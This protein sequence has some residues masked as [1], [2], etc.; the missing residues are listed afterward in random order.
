[1]LPVLAGALMPLLPHILE[2]QRSP[3]KGRN[4]VRL[5]KV[6]DVVLETPDAATFPE[7]VLV[8]EALFLPR[9]PTVLPRPTLL[10]ALVRPVLLAV[11][12]VA[13]PE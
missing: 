5:T 10:V 4:A 1:M 8:K 12:L 9:L 7:L 11:S 2:S 3:L 6:A 13:S